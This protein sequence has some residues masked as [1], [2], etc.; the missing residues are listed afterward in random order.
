[1]ALAC[2]AGLALQF[3]S[4][5]G[6]THDV[7]QTL[8][9]IARFFTILT[10]FALGIVMTLTALRRRLS[11]F[12]L[13]GVTIAIILVGIV[14]AVLLAGLHELHG[15]ALAADFL[16]HKV[17]PVAMAAWWLLFAPH[18]KLRWS[19]ATGWS[20]YPLAYFAYALARGQAD[21]KYPYPF[22]DVGKLGWQQTLL[23]AGGIAFGF[24]L[25]GLLLVALDRALPAGA[26]ARR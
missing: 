17:S 4:T 22:M 2:W 8:W 13:G 14:Y 6:Q 18:G 12:L 24:I 5:Q 20:L 7:G 10:N 15:I 26:K 23:N 16:L 3:T 25:A 9:I 11:P 19:A 1:M 21:G